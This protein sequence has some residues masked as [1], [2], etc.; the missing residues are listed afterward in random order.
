MQSLRK[1]STIFL[2]NNDATYAIKGI[3]LQC[4]PWTRFLID[5]PAASGR[6]IKN[7]ING[8]VTNGF[9]FAQRA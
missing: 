3:K 6:G 1:K 5:N 2:D 4:E 9:K 8:A 7:L